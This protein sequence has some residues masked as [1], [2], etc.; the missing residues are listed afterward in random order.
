MVRVHQEPFTT[1]LYTIQHYSK[2]FSLSLSKCF[3]SP[4]QLATLASL[5]LGGGGGGCFTSAGDLAL[6]SDEEE[7]ALLL[8]EAGSKVNTRG[9]G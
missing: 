6:Y 1:V 4:L 9:G 5:N 2:T 7:A 8:L 3:F